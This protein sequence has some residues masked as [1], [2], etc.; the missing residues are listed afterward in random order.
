MCLLK[1]NLV[2]FLLHQTQN[3]LGN[4]C[5]SLQLRERVKNDFP[6]EKNSKADFFFFFKEKELGRGMG[7]T[8]QSERMRENMPHLGRFKCSLIQQMMVALPPW[9]GPVT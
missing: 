9:V 1:Q 4:W 8:L 5:P 2:P 6:S 3:L 7:K